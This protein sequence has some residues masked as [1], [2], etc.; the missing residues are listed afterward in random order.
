[1]WAEREMRIGVEKGKGPRSV[2][3]SL[4]SLNKDK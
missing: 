2:E 4:H 1:M 3:N